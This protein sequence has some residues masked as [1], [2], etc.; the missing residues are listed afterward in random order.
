MTKHKSTPLS[1]A[2]TD[3]PILY[4]CDTPIVMATMYT[5]DSIHVHH[6]IQEFYGI[7]QWNLKLKIELPSKH[8]QI[9]CKF[10]LKYVKETAQQRC[11]RNF[12]VKCTWVE[13]QSKLT[14][15][16]LIASLSNRLN[17]CFIQHDI[18]YVSTW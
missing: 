6:N 4:V 12:N 15:E 10:L 1:F 5:E 18:A 16:S 9:M 11:Y 3:N 7:L 8:L 17:I 13:P 2:V 14:T